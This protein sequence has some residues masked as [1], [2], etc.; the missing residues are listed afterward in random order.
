[1]C[2]RYNRYNCQPSRPAC[3]GNFAKPCG[4]AIRRISSALSTGGD[5]YSALPPGVSR[6]V[7]RSFPAQEPWRREKPLLAARRRSGWLRYYSANVHSWC[8]VI[9]C[10]G[11]PQYLYRLTS[12]RLHPFIG[13]STSMILKTRSPSDILN[14]VHQSVNRAD[15]LLDPLG[16]LP[17]HSAGVFFCDGHPTSST[18]HDP[19][20]TRQKESGTGAGRGR[21][22]ADFHGPGREWWPRRRRFHSLSSARPMV[23]R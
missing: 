22:S 11:Q 8:R 3:S 2:A 19:L 17:Y 7:A 21:R 20:L 15:L 9:W 14:H 5:T 23:L 18:R 16:T 6:R 1:M 12:L 4:G 13:T 10:A